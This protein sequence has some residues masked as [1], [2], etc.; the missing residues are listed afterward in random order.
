[1]TIASRAWLVWGLGALSFSY[2]FFQRVA[3]SVMLVDLMRD[4]AV[5]AAVLGNLSAI[6]L[7]AY[8]GLQM[9]IGLALDRWGARRMLSGAAVVAAVGCVAFAAAQGVGI[10]YLGRLLI[11]IGSAVGF[12]GALKL[13]THWFAPGRFAFVSGLTMMVAMLGA[14]AGQVPL[15]AVVGVVGWR[16][17]MLGAA[18]FAVLLAAASWMVIRDRPPGQKSVQQS[19]PVSLRSSLARVMAGRQ[20][21]ILALYGG[22]MT[23]P[24]LAYGGLWGVMHQMRLYDLDRISAAGSNSLMLVGWA[25]GAPLGGWISDRL[26]RRRMPMTAAAVLSL[27]GWLVLLYTPALPLLADRILLF[28]IGATSGAMVICIAAARERSPAAVSGA[29]TGFINTAM[30]GS[31]ALMQPLIGLLLDANWDGAMQDGA[32]LYSPAAFD[33]ALVTLPVCA[34]VA[35]AASLLVPAKQT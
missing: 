22:A 13:A 16:A 18:G 7:Y 27:V 25:V 29:V 10:A 19:T 33:A 17:A 15:A 2:A 6:Y 32:R 34:A 28:V 4:F 30:V 11:G 23:A 12:V 3:P 24:F 8:A 31:G 35:V 1:M 9:P 20:N 5:G 14:V 26:G 21:W